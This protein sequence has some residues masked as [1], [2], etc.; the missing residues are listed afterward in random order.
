MDR[1]SILKPFY[2]VVYALSVQDGVSKYLLLRRSQKHS[3]GLWQ[4]PC[5]GIKDGE[6]AWEAALRELMEETGLTPEKLYSS[7]FV[8]LYYESSRDAVILAPVFVALIDENQEVKLSPLEH[9]A[10]RWVAF[11]EALDLVEF[12]NQK[13]AI[14]H[15]EETFVK[16]TPTE[17]LVIDIGTNKS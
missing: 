9:D 1:F 3:I 2:S 4:A 12:A 16:N 6:K 13:K 11:E 14:R 17:R 10:F 5:G 15:I 7:D 8:E